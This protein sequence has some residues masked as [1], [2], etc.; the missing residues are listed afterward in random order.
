MVRP[1]F[2]LFRIRTCIRAASGFQMSAWVIWRTPPLQFVWTTFAAIYRWNP[3][4]PRW[5]NGYYVLANYGW[6]CC[7][8]NCIDGRRVFAKDMALYIVKLDEGVESIL[9]VCKSRK[10]WI[11]FSWLGRRHWLVR[12]YRC[13]IGDAREETN[14]RY[15]DHDETGYRELRSL[16]DDI[17]E[18]RQRRV[19]CTCG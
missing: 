1:A 5:E 16:F 8:A 17:Q 6:D 3:T 4:E 14:F 19:Q 13:C 11:I 18:H 2:C 12:Y 15:Y 10:I 9:S 7:P